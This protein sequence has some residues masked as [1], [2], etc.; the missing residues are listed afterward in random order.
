MLINFNAHYLVTDLVVGYNVY[1]SN[2]AQQGDPK[3]STRKMERHFC[4][5]VA[6]L[7]HLR[8]HYPDYAT[9]T[10][11]VNRQKLRSSSFVVSSAHG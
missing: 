6:I 11:Q 5:Q 8:A 7:E 9:T 1:A 10:D 4:Y 3:N 2:N